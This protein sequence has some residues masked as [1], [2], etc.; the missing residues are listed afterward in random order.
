[1]NFKFL[2]CNSDSFQVFATVGGD[3]LSAP[4][5][6]DM[7]SIGPLRDRRGCPKGAGVAIFI[8]TRINWK[9]A[10]S[11]IPKRKSALGFFC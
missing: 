7:R 10:H 9:Q 1:M 3:A 2:P 8:H 4:L 11:K 6:K 5:S